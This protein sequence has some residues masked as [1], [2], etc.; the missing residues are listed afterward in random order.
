MVVLLKSSS[1]Y[2][3]SGEANGTGSIVRIV[4]TPSTVEMGDHYR[5]SHGED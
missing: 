3:R 4:P 1:S 5:S 2:R